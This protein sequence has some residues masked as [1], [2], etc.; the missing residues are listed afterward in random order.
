MAPFG[1]G[2]RQP[3][4]LPVRG[5][6]SDVAKHFGLARDP[7]IASDSK[8]VAQHLF[9]RVDRRK[10]FRTLD[11]LHP[12][13]CADAVALAR[14]GHGHS[15]IQQGAHEWRTL[16]DGDL[17]Q[18]FYEADHGHALLLRGAGQEGKLTHMN[19]VI[20]LG[21][22]RGL[23]AEI[24]KKAGAEG[25][26]VTGF[27]RKEAPLKTLGLTVPGFEFHLADLAKLQGQDTV[28]RF[29]LE[30]EVDKIFC[31]AGGGPYGPFGQA[32][33]K[34]HDWA[35]EVTF[36]SHARVLHALAQARR[37]PQVILVGS[38]VAESEGDLG[39]ASY[40]AAKHA[41][42]GLHG[43]LRLDYPAWDLRLVSP[44]YMNTSLLPL[45][46]TVREGG[47]YEPID[48]ANDVWN[49]CKSADIGGHKLYAKHPF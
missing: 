17:G 27:S 5:I 22:S 33:W 23:G 15:R 37:F 21:A 8:S 43:S 2:V 14:A 39:A 38:S 6:D 48:V 24:V 10:I 34:D 30:N 36:R 18:V 40:A 11:H 44:G 19:R 16:G 1:E 28:I 47:V 26:R 41:L 31:V 49:W 20:V 42:K 3:A 46:S 29:L 4:C 7:Q 25:A 35:W 13:F 9:A 45:N 32:N 12:A